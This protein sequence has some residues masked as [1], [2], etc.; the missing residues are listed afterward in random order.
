MSEPQRPEARD[1]SASAVADG[2]AEEPADRNLSIDRRGTAWVEP[3][4]EAA[5][6]EPAS[7]APLHLNNRRGSARELGASSRTP[8]VEDGELPAVCPAFR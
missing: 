8:P 5:R 1:G 4:V 2:R 7:E 3:K 6:I